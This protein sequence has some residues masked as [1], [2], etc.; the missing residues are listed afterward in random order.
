MTYCEKLDIAMKPFLSLNDTTK[1]LGT[2]YRTLKPVWDEMILNLQDQ[3]GKKF[4]SWGI[5]THLVMDYFDI[6]LSRIQ[7]KAEAEKKVDA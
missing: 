2:T 7:M 3:T 5:P 6:E 4:G 1:L